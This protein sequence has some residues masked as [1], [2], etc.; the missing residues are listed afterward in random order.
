ME[1]NSHDWPTHKQGEV[2]RQLILDA[3]DSPKTKEELSSLCNKSVRQIT[4]HLQRLSSENKILSNGKGQF[5]RRIAAGFLL[6]YVG[7]I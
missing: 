5:V 1:F 6:L 4:R 7:Q 3:L 2:V